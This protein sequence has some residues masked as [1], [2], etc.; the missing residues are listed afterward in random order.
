MKTETQTN[1]LPVLWQVLA[2]VLT[3]ALTVAAA[4]VG[5]AI[6]PFAAAMALRTAID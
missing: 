3:L 5:L 6:A 2:I 1:A 4:M